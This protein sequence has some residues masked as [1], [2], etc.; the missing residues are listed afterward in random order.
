MEM[1]A[2]YEAAFTSDAAADGSESEPRSDDSAI[3]ELFPD[4]AGR[5]AVFRQHLRSLVLD[6]AGDDAQ[7]PV[8][9]LS[10]RGSG[11]AAARLGAAR[12]LAAA[13]LF[14]DP[15]AHRRTGC[16][17]DQAAGGARASH[18]SAALGAG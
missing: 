9:D 6:C 14:A 15:H 10:V 4:T 17:S 12:E 7:G 18:V 1:T 3:A 13:P 8:A 5:G 11:D 2:S 16:G